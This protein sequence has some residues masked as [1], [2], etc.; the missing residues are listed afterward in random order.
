MADGTVYRL[1]PISFFNKLNDY[2]TP[3][4]QRSCLDKIILKLKLMD[5][6]DPK[7]IL[8]ETIEPPSY[9]EICKT[10]DYLKN[11]GAINARGKISRFGKIYADMPFDIRI[12]RL[13][14]FSILFHCVE[15]AVICASI[16]S[17]EKMPITNF[18][19]MRGIDSQKHPLTYIQRLKLSKDS[20]SDL[21]MY[22]NLFKI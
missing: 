22:L 10:E 12:T 13:V 1:I 5:I 7:T 4:I 14:L 21:I 2:P 3:E 15:E 17:L 8:A 16:L 9:L 20:N 19:N 11:M 6:S 18:S